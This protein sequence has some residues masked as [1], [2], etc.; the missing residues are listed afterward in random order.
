MSTSIQ[1]QIDQKLSDEDRDWI[2]SKFSEL[3]GRIDAMAT[4]SEQLTSLGTSLNELQA[5]L[6][7]YSADVAQVIDWWHNQRGN[8]SADEQSQM[9]AIVASLADTRQRVADLDVAVGDTDNSDVPPPPVEE[10]VQP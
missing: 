7:D 6:V 1:I 3:N 9:D 5:A 10:P 8:F 2:E 4:I